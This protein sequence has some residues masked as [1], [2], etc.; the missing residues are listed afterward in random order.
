M[1]RRVFLRSTH[2][3]LIA[4]G[5]LAAAAVGEIA[6][7]V[8]GFSYVNFDKPDIIR[9]NSLRPKLAG[10]HFREGMAYVEINSHGYRDLERTKAKPDGVYRIAVLGDSFVE[11]R[12]VA[13]EQTFCAVLERMLNGTSGFKGRTVEVLNFGVSGYGTAQELLTLRHD[14][15]GF[16]PDQVILVVFT[17]NDVADNSQALSH[18]LRARPYFMLRG[19]QTRPGHFF[20][21]IGNFHGA[22]NLDGRDFLRVA[23]LLAARA[24]GLSGQTGRPRRPAVR[25]GAA[26]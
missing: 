24:T 26:S 18:K 9:G 2:L 8:I 17:A 19:E 23:G 21:A 6:L 3:L 12:E 10:W 14:V 13:L 11:G 25:C 20:P 7:R 1:K 16:D 15:Y 5:I 22:A 4:G